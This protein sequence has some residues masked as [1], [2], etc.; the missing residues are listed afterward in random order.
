MRSPAFVAVVCSP[1][2]E[3]TADTESVFQAAM[4]LMDFYERFLVLAE[5]S[6]G[7][8]AP[9]DYSDLLNNCARLPDT[10][11]HGAALLPPEWECMTA[12]R[13]RHASDHP[14]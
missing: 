8:A 6:R 14:A 2:D 7:L 4:R 11:N 9:S 12:D 10:T 3:A 13:H 1:H 5:R